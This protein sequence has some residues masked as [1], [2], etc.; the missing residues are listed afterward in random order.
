M[1]TLQLTMA[2][3]HATRLDERLAAGDDPVESQELAARA[4]LLLRPR[5]RHSLATG[6]RRAVAEARLGVCA[7]SSAVRVDRPGV[8]ACAPEL[9]AL[10][11]ELGDRGVRPQG[12]ALTRLLL[13]DGSGPLYQPGSECELR[14]EVDAARAAL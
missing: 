5:M 7:R 1:G 13:C 8:A 2:R 3:L 6:L 12:V 10:A 4:A 11:A 14:Q 9:L